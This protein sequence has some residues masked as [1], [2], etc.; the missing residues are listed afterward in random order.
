M[1][2]ASRVSLL[3][4][5]AALLLL[6]GCGTHASVSDTTSSGPGAG[7]SSPGAG[8]QGQSALS[9]VTP[10]PEGTGPE[11][12]LPRSK[13]GVSVS[14][15]ALPI[16][17]PVGTPEFTNNSRYACVDV[18]WLGTIRDPVTVTVTG[19]VV[20]D[21]PFESVDEATAGCSAGAPRC[22]GLTIT[23]AGDNSTQCIAAVRWT[24]QPAPNGGSIELAGSLSCHGLGPAACQQIVNKV[25]SDALANGPVQFDFPVPSVTDSTSP[26]VTDTPSPPAS[27][28][29]APTPANA[30][31]P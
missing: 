17:G 31:S 27:G 2:R 5:A 23:A 3:A 7:S 18:S 19:V 13:A 14:V 9:T 10:R 29:P 26:P 16:G 6:V 24:G 11:S 21:G 22:V 15:A 28:T 1:F 30:S 8:H 12:P 25:R 20:V 4:V